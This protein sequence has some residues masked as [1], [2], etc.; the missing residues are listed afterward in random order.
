MKKLIL[1][2]FTA[3]ALCSPSAFADEAS[4]AKELKVLKEQLKAQQE[5]IS[6]LEKK[7]DK[8]VASQAKA[9]SNLAPA[10]GGVKGDVKIS[11]KP[12]PKIESSDG[13]YSFQPLGRIHLDA[14]VFD[15]DM[16]DHPDGATFRR[17]RLGFKGT[18]DEDV[19]YKAELDFGNKSGTQS[20]SFKDVYLA[21]TGFEHANIKFG[22]FKPSYGLEELTSSNYL[23][24]VERSLPTGSFATGEIIGAQVYDGG[25][26][27]SWALGFHN[28]SSSIKSADDEAKSVAGRVTYAPLAEDGKVLHL[29]LSQVYRVPDSAADSVAFDTKAENS[30][31]TLESAETGTIT[32]VDSIYL[33]GLEAAGVYG[34][35]SLQGEYFHN[36]IDRETASDLDVNGWYAQASYLVTGES[37]PYS[38]KSGTFGRV[39]PNN[40]F[41]LKN[42]GYGALELAARYSNIDLNDGTALQGGEVDNITLGANW[43]LNANTR[44]MANYIMVDTDGVT[45]SGANVAANDDP[46]I[47]LFRAAIDF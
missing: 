45:P 36:S 5:M 44:L 27:Y 22:N 17:M 46:N 1:S 13:K 41:S 19:Q 31:Q 7:L 23:T 16:N 15:D 18:V 35:L 39:K 29:G 38:A 21:Y 14:A 25:D 4:L 42:G 20:V 40:P 11:M 8:E 10:A 3:I 43:Y 34:S 9:L 12:S 33:T 28:D 47:W 32:G 6:K 2:S 26:N 37:R 30:I 24:F